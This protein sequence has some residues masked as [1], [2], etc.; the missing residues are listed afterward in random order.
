M[1]SDENIS[2]DTALI[3]TDARV[4]RLHSYPRLALDRSVAQR[5]RSFTNDHGW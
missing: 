5:A 2:K 1:M 4:Y 3:L